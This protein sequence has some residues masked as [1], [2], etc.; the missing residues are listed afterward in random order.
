MFHGLAA[1][2]LT[3][4]DHIRRLP[5]G[6]FEGVFETVGIDADLALGDDAAAVLMYILDRILHR[7]NMAIAVVVAIAHHRSEGGGFAG[8]SR[9]H[10]NHQTTLGH[11]QLHKV[12]RQA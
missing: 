1:A 12:V 3:D 10:H 7:H 5:Q 9:P 8:A 2:N 6:I 11:G 4:H